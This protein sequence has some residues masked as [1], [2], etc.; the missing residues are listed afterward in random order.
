MATLN[1]TCQMLQGSLY[2]QLAQNTV[3]SEGWRYTNRMA[4]LG[5]AVL[6]AIT[7]LLVWHTPEEVG[8]TPD[9]APAPAPPASLYAASSDDEASGKREVGDEEEEEGEGSEEQGL[10]GGGVSSS[11]RDYTLAEAKRTA[12]LPLLS[13]CTG[14]FAFCWAATDFYLIAIVAS[15]SGTFGA[16]AVDLATTYYLPQSVGACLFT[17]LGGVLVDR[18]VDP[19]RLMVVAGF[20]CAANVVLLTMS[21]AVL[22]NIAAGV[23]RGICLSGYGTVSGCVYGQYYGRTHLGAITS[24]P[25]ISVVVFSAIGPLA[26]GVAFDLLG[27]FTLCLFLTAAF[28]LALSLCILF[29]VRKPPPMPATS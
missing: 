17:I 11:F 29:C 23:T 10:L 18:G 20:S 16:G 8:C 3:A 7:S 5:C 21:G 9:G 27:S 25:Q 19:A 1:F 24:Y 26:F 14:S 15:N 12:A 6:A 22:A 13:L 28:P 2:A 4:A